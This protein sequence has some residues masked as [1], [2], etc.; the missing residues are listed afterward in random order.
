M[1][2]CCKLFLTLNLLRLQSKN[3]NSTIIWLWLDF[4]IAWNSQFLLTLCFLITPR[5][6]GT[7]FVIRILCKRMPLKILRYEDIFSLCLGD[8]SLANYYS[9]FKGMNDWLDQ[10][11]P[12]IDNLETARRQREKLC[13]CKFLSGLHTS[14]QLLCG[15]LLTREIGIL[16][17]LN[18]FS[19]LS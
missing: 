3:G 19:H 18:I 15:Q 14:L 9:Q 7:V 11:Y 10:Y 6:S 5:R 1:V 2:A 8:Q 17:P 4:G 13:V 16:I 12:L